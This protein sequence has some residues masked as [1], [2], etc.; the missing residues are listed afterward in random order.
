MEGKNTLKLYV[1]GSKST[2]SDDWEAWQEIELI[3]AEDVSQVKKL[4]A[5]PF[6]DITEIPLTGKARVLYQ[7]SSIEQWLED[8]A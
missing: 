3:L 6:K 8:D 4:C 2:N 1:V 5:N 7:A